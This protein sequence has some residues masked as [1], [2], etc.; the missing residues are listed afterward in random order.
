MADGPTADLRD[1]DR[2][3]LDAAEH[4]IAQVTTADLDRPTPCTAWNLGDLL[5]HMVSENSGFAAAAA[6]T[7]AQRSIWYGG[8][9]GTDPYRA[10]HDSAAAVTTAFAVPDFYDRRI[11]VREFGVFRAR[12]AVSMH[13]V[14]FLVHGWDVAASIGAPYRPDPE[15]TAT[16]L[17]IA[18]R[19]PDTPEFRGPDAAFDTRVAVPDDAP[20]LERL[21]GL[22][23][24]VEL[25]G[26]LLSHS[27]C[28]KP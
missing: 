21:L 25:F 1:L 3:A 20:N 24:A 17:A 11:E 18:S 27:T 2:R 5:R 8:D 26:D 13:L 15:L 16:A 14:D 10:Y 6:G 4:V 19:W 23:G 7:P 22:L 28:L 12:V 9:L